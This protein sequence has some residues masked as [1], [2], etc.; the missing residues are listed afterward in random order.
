L[1]NAEYNELSNS[2]AVI[3]G[4]L[5]PEIRR[6]Q[7]R[8]FNDPEMNF[9]YLIAT[10]AIGMGVNLKIRRIIFQTLTRMGSEGE[11]VRI[12]DNEIRQIAGRA[13]RYTENG[14]VACMKPNDLKVVKKALKHVNSHV[15]KDTT[16][17]G[18][19]EINTITQT[20]TVTEEGL[21]EIEEEKEEEFAF[22]EEEEET[23]E[24]EDDLV[25]RSF[26]QDERNIEKAAIFPQFQQIEAFSKELE[27]FEN[28]K[29]TL[30]DIF[31]KFVS[32]A[33]IEG[34]Y[35]IQR[36]D[37]FCYIADMIEKVQL[38]RKDQYIFSSAPLNLNEKWKKARKT[39]KEFAE[40][41][42]YCG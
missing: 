35:F 3:Y 41:F 34:T 17:H 20:K 29:N 24:D 21:I 30:S 13:G 6:E 4:K 18:V 16:V 32:I 28:S 40:Q 14:Y 33:Q 38:T 7:A 25:A 10:N 42:G 15:R 2:C 1:I 27:L 19:V 37:N 23:E 11:L 26:S 39:L 12:D 31:R 36:F 5:P 22:V 8:K 9:K